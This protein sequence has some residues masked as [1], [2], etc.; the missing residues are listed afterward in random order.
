MPY[1][2]FNIGLYQHG[3]DLHSLKIDVLFDVDLI[4][5]LVTKAIMLEL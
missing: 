3:R 1:C 4:I 2:I 5:K